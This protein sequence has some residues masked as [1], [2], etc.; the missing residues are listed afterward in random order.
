MEFGWNGGVTFG[1][2]LLWVGAVVYIWS[3]DPALETAF[4]LN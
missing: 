3:C 4:L 2:N 1:T